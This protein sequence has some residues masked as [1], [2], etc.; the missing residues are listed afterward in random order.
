MIMKKIYM[1]VLVILAILGLALPAMGEDCM[2]H[3][4]TVK[5]ETL[6][7]KVTERTA[8]ATYGNLP[9]YPASV[10]FAYT[11]QIT[12]AEDGRPIPEE[13]DG[14]AQGAILCEMLLSEIDEINFS[15]L[16]AINEVAGDKMGVTVTDG[17]MRISR[18]SEPV[19][20]T[21]ATLAGILAY[22]RTISS[23]T[24]ID[25]NRYGKGIYTVA[26][27]SLTFKILVE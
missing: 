15:G 7:V 20:V 11:G 21:V 14:V 22:D 25:L 9:A 16:S 2:M 23:D 10:F 17:V 26:A 5:G 18:A 1:K 19:H 27:G 6:D 3:I 8:A 13:I 4:R 24:E 12:T